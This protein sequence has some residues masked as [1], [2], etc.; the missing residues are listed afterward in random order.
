MKKILFSNRVWQ[1]FRLRVLGNGSTSS[2]ISLGL[3][4]TIPLLEDDGTSIYHAQ[5]DTV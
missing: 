1:L 3:G 4:V 2:D 5:V